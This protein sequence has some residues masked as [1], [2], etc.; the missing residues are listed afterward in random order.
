[1]GEGL[2]TCPHCG[3][4]LAI[5]NSKIIPITKDALVYSKDVKPLIV[6]EKRFYT[7][8]PEIDSQHKKIVELVNKI[9][10]QLKTSARPANAVKEVLIELK[11][12]VKDHFAFEEKMFDNSDYP[13][14]ELHKAKHVRFTNHIV[15]LTNQYKSSPINIRMILS[16]L[17]EW[18]IEHI[19]G[20]D[21]EYVEYVKKK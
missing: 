2:L 17:I 9:N 16:M 12:Y 7:H 15:E 5:E 1:M 10:F 21:M 6:W 8:I 14:T 19:A 3:G 20:T 11:N 13:Y 18:F 4:Q